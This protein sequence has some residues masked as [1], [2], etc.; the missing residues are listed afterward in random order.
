MDRPRDRGIVYD[1][2]RWEGIELRRGDIV[3]STPPKC[4]TTWTQMICYLLILQEPELDR[5]LA[6]ISPWLD[7]VG[8]SRRHRPDLTA[9]R[10]GQSGALVTDSG[11]H[12]G[13]P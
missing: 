4:G 9:R 2:A 8:R 3:I 6:E 1:S 13:G 12:R 10:R 7:N 11:H 5:P